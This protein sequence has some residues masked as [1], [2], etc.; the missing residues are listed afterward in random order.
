MLGELLSLPLFLFTA[1][2]MEYQCITM[3]YCFM[4]CSTKKTPTQKTKT[5]FKNKTNASVRV[6]LLLRPLY[7]WKEDS[8]CVPN[9]SNFGYICKK[10]KKNQ[11]EWLTPILCNI[12]NALNHVTKTNG[13]NFTRIIE[14]KLYTLK[15]AWD[16]IIQQ[17]T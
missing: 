17:E 1:V 3:T 12:I 7:R 10:K 13:L 2:S 15:M 6:K 16:I 9:M 5:C 4:I 14:T 11:G 8:C